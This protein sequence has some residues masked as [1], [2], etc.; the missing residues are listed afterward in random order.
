M[1]QRRITG[2]FEYLR[3]VAGSRLQLI[4]VLKV[5]TFITLVSQRAHSP[6]LF[7]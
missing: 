5:F 3:I 7:T 4:M 6:P 1:L 2:G